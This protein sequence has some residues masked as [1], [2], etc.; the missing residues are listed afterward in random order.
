MSL[1]PA[2]DLLGVE[3][4]MDGSIENNITN[5]IKESVPEA[6]ELS[7]VG[8][9]LSFQLP[10]DSSGQFAEIFSKLDNF[11]DEKKI[12]TYGVSITT[13]D[14]VFL[15]VA[16][17]E[18]KKCDSVLSLPPSIE[19]TQEDDIV[20]IP[21][22][23]SNES[24]DL[25]ESKLTRSRAKAFDGVVTNQSTSRHIQALFVK[26]AKNFQRDK[27]AWFCSVIL[28]AVLALSGF[29]Q[30]KY[31]FTDKNLPPL[32]L[33]IE[34]QN[35]EYMNENERN[36]ISFNT[37][38]TFMCSPGRCVTQDIEFGLSTTEEK[39]FMCGSAASLGRDAICSIYGT[40]EIMRS[41]SSD[42]VMLVE[43]ETSTTI[44]MVSTDGQKKITLLYDREK[45]NF[46]LLI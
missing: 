29:L 37:A 35:T 45:S 33:S 34:N 12:V 9:E 32:V 44:E 19:R 6:K 18:D 11:V 21:Q 20:S 15:M 31:G 14:E 43:D 24:F 25:E 28:P 1:K 30:M 41:L 7:N 17:G 27:K 13:L 4:D 42:G 10:L 2:V 36:P 5:L 40:D 16:R 22:S 39:Y 46:P 38:E 26:R 23:L 8:T 3:N